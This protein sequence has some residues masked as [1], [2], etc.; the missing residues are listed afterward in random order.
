MERLNPG[1]SSMLTPSDI[2]SVV[3]AGGDTGRFGVETIINRTVGI[4]RHFLYL[5]SAITRGL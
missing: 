5:Y 1:I 2:S 3:L 4:L